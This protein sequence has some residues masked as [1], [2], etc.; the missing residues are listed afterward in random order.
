MG[1]ITHLL[2]LCSFCMTSLNAQQG[3]VAQAQN[4]LEIAGNPFNQVTA[5]TLFIVAEPNQSETVVREMKKIGQVKQCP[6]L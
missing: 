1:V 5:F 3:V 6:C 2:V 4:N